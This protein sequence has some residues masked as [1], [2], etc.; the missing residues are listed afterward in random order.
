MSQISASALNPAAAGAVRR[1]PENALA[2]LSGGRDGF[3]RAL[4][5]LQTSANAESPDAAGETKH[6]ALVGEMP[7]APLA[8]PS[9]AQPETE[10]FEQI[11]RRDGSPSDSDSS[12]TSSMASPKGSTEQPSNNEGAPALVLDR[13]LHAQQRAVES[14][15]KGGD[16]GATV[17]ASARNTDAEA[18]RAV[19]AVHADKVGVIVPASTPP[20]DGGAARDQERSP[21]IVETFA[22]AS[23]EAKDNTNNQG[24]SA[25]V[26][27]SAP[28]TSARGVDPEGR[29]KASE[30]TIEA[31]TRSAA[32]EDDHPAGAA[33]VETHE[34]VATASTPASAATAKQ[35]VKHAPAEGASAAST[36]RSEPVSVAKEAHQGASAAKASV[37][38]AETRAV[39][40]DSGL[41][42]PRPEATDGT[43]REV[44]GW[45]V[46]ERFLSKASM[47][48]TEAGKVMAASKAEAPAL[49]RALV[50]ELEQVLATRSE[51][52]PARLLTDVATG[53]GT[54]P[55]LAPVTAPSLATA[56]SATVLAAG[57]APA[58]TPP[59]PTAAPQQM[60]EMAARVLVD[61]ASEGNWRVSLRL[62]PPDMGRMDVQIAREQG[63][64]TAH[65]VASTPA[66]RAAMEQ[67]MP[68]LQAQMAEQ[69]MN[70]ADSSVSQEQPGHSSDGRH[71]ETGTGAGSTASDGAGEPLVTQAA[72]VRRA[73]GL[74]EGWA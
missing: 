36:T 2:V 73:H 50:R 27:D 40:A 8:T 56:T 1:S 12:A 72:T 59:L 65:F 71:A 61:A 39:R 49:P 45:S 19:L 28:G 38:H 7:D 29:D 34:V 69:G 30:A 13:M 18:E 74:F 70:L 15:A 4:G 24:A 35:D 42:G 32:N 43:A 20:S 10:A 37:S 52:G 26:P 46:A 6:K 16:S 58:G 17:E 64:L 63:G 25:L 31:S 5:Q 14:K 48:D 57:G 22:S 60:A 55:G 9:T 53:S 23:D 3:A 47:E 62:D 54:S 66:A 44:R 41:P 21:A 11:S 67:A 68:M 33:H 51:S